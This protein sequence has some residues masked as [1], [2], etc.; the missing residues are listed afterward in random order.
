MTVLL[1]LAGIALIALAA[2]G[3]DDESPGAL[4]VLLF[5][6]CLAGILAARKKPDDE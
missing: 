3:L 5:L 4:D 6:L 2:R 1:V